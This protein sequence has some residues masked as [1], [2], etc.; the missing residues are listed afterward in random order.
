VCALSAVG[1]VTDSLGID[2][3][4]PIALLIGFDHPPSFTMSKLDVHRDD[5]AGLPAYFI[6]PANPSTKYVV[7]LHSG[8]FVVQPTINHWSAYAELG[9]THPGDGHR[10]DLSVGVDL[11]R[12]GADC[13]P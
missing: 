6:R 13:D 4:T 10:A 5:S 2:L 1:A 12:Q 3:G 9:Q 8:A 11:R 7:A